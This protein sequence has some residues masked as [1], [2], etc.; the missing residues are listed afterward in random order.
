MTT[1]QT[2][3]CTAQ[4]GTHGSTR[5]RPAEGSTEHTLQFQLAISRAAL[6]LGEHCTGAAQQS[7]RNK[8]I[9]KF[10]GERLGAP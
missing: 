6:R 8:N 4:H 9:A 3:V 2:S 1:L 10:T 7:T 5:H